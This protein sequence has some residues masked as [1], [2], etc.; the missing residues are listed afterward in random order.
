M[1]L[2]CP[3][4]SHQVRRFD[5][6]YSF[7]LSVGEEINRVSPARGCFVFRWRHATQTTQTTTKCAVPG[8]PVRDEASA[9]QRH[10]GGVERL[11]IHLLAAAHPPRGVPTRRQAVEGGG[12]KGQGEGSRVSENRPFIPSA[13]AAFQVISGGGEGALVRGVPHPPCFQVSPREAVVVFPAVLD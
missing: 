3:D 10:G 2:A 5:F 11:D 4:G 8:G 1:D 9:G 13:A 12:S 6:C 7:V